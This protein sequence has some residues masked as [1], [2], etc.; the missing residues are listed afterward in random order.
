MSVKACGGPGRA[1]AVHGRR[2][3]QGALMNPILP[4]L[5][6]PITVIVLILGVVLGSALALLRMPVDI[7]PN[8]NPPVIYVIQAYGGMDPAQMEG[9]PTNYYEYHF[10]YIS[11]I[12]HV[13]SRNIQGAAVMK[14]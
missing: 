8:L 5:E 1:A 9:L 6:R 13:E 14:L 10:L 2:D 7:F 11:G 3:V 12:H 4:A